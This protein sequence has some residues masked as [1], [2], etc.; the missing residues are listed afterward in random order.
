MAYT[1]INKSTEHFN[2]KLY[3]GNGGTN[4]I[5]GVGHQPDMVW[6]KNRTDG[7][8]HKLFDSVRGA[9]KVIEPN[10]SATESTYANSLASFDSDGFTIGSTAD[11][12]ESSDNF[13]SWNWKAGTTSGLSGGT[14][15]PTAY[16]INASSGVGIYKYTGNS[17][18][19]ATIAHGL[20]K[21][22]TS[23]WVKRLDSAKEWQIYHQAMGNGKWIELTS[24]TPQT[25]TSRWN[26]TSP[27][28]TLFYLGNDSDVNYNGAS[29][30]AYVFCDVTGFSK[31]GSY[32]GNANNDG[33]FVYTGFKPSW[34]MIKRT[35]SN[36]NWHMFDVV[37]NPTYPT[38]SSY[39][40]M[41]TR[42]M[43]N[44]SNSTDL[45]Q[46]GFRFLSNG[47]KMTTSWSGGNGSG[48]T[49]IY[50][51][52]GQALVGSNNTPCTAR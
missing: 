24:G 7:D 18:S 38:N 26:D 50:W 29:Y 31:M 6:L 34:L 25:G 15:T 48:D 21:I 44:L 39:D 14:I 36:E 9:L 52:F 11:I 46:G 35:N 40:G 23:I 13:V 4:A 8:G 42:L 28:S 27:T 20:G 16:S 43:A 30:V 45:S 17:T 19:G 1:T 47:L 51:C 22:P 32:T 49:F 37:R 10:D 12:N 41:A 3:V 33:V 5:T 2:T